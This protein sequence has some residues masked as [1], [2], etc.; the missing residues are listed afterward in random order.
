[1]LAG[2]YEYPTYYY[3]TYDKPYAL[4]EHAYGYDS[5]ADTD[6]DTHNRNRLLIWILVPIGGFIGFLILV[7]IV[8]AAR[9]QQRQSRALSVNAAQTR[10]TSNKGAYPKN[11]CSL[12]CLWVSCTDFKTRACVCYSVLL[13][14]T[15]NI[16]TCWLDMPLV[17]INQCASVCKENTPWQITNIW[18]AISKMC[19]DV[20]Y[21]PIVLVCRAAR[22]LLANVVLLGK[23]W[24]CFR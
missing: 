22:A 20:K 9:R 16:Q 7:G 8:C 23:F 17:F 24:P 21:L 13:L 18:R 15:R 10:G 11:A 19:M 6:E 2:A 14:D 4:E 12:L 5:D 1:M 3:K